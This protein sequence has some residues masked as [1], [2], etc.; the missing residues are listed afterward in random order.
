MPKIIR[1]DL[2]E[3]PSANRYWRHARGRTY[4]AAE[5][6]AYRVTV[7]AAYL[8]EFG[9][10]IAF[11]TGPIKLNVI[12]YRARKSGDLSNRIK[13]LEDALRSLAYTDDNQ[14]TELHMWRLDDALVK[15]RVV[16]E[17]SGP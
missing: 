6:K 12:W 10:K 7:K 16:V 17:V 11:P 2:P 1:L 13:Q 14:T 5:A 15:G 8:K 3:P 9:G 4:L